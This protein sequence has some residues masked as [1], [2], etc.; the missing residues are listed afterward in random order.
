MK[1]LIL[2]TDFLKDA[3]GNLRIIETN[4]NVDVHNQ[5]VPQLNWNAFKQ[6]LIDN[7]IT[8]LHFIYTDG[9]F[10]VT[11][12][13][14]AFDTT[15]P[16]V[17]LKDKI[18]EIMNEISGTFNYYE[19][20]KNSITVPYIE[21]ATDTLI[22]RTSYDTTAIVDE[23]YTKD[24]VN[25]HR[26]ISNETFRPNVYYH[27]ETDTN[28]NIDQ[29]ITLHVTDGDT[30]NYIVKTRYP[31]VDYI[32][33]PKLYKIQSLE[34][35]TAL[36]E[37][38]SDSEY[39]E[40]YHTHSENFVNNKIGVIRSLDIVYGNTLSTLHLGSYIMTSGVK[41]NEY[42]TTYGTDGK[43]QQSSRVLW[44]T[45]SPALK[46]TSA[47]ILDDDTPIM[48]AD[49]TFKYPNQILTNDSLKTLTFDWIPFNET[50]ENGEPLYIPDVNSGSFA[51]DLATFTQATASVVEL[52]TQTKESLMIR[53]T[54]ENGIVYE[55]LPSSVMLLEE[56]DTLQT[57]FVFTNR[58]RINDSIVFF[59][60]VNNTL[61]KS[62][63]TNLEIV[64]A[65]RKIYDINVEANDIFLPLADETLGL[66]FVQHNGQCFG[67]C[68]A[69][70]CAVWCCNACAFCPGAP[71]S[72]L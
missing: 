23:N 41:N 66:T 51:N 46:S 22:L 37:S 48:Y 36:K 44:L 19:V 65:N 61:V 43:M 12:K 11:E 25:F 8:K 38:L 57:T 53:V 52:G 13:E 39:I 68:A 21:D 3:T 27:S 58:F 2:G 47:Y 16:N 4:T 64:Y 26:L 32:T 42:N 56:Y 67:W 14:H 24:K 31:N 5:V 20:P 71:P 60:Y 70:T 7:S 18:S 30:P 6:F 55:D 34:N 50:G 69:W 49:G 72:K 29:L 9:N 33:Y 45:K 15:S 59:D 28:L 17:S 35:L 10:I 62:K 63:I 40:E 54:L 1:G